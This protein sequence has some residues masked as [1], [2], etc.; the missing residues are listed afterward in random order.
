MMASSVQS[1]AYR[2]GSFTLDLGRGALLADDG[3]E[4]ALRPKSFALLRLLVE[5][6]GQLLSREAIMEALWPNVFVTEDNV[7]QCIHDIR[8]ILGAD[9]LQ[10]LRTVPRRGYLFATEVVTVTPADPWQQH[11]GMDNEAQSV[12]P[13]RLQP[14]RLPVAAQHT[15]GERSKLPRA[16]VRV[17]SLRIL[18]IPD[19]QR[20]L[21]DGVIEDICGHL[22]LWKVPVVGFS[23]ASPYIDDLIGRQN[24]ARD[25]G[26]GYLLQGSARSADD[27][28]EVN[29]Q[30]VDTEIG[31]YVWSERLSI[32]PGETTDA[33]I[34]ASLRVAR[35][36]WKA[37]GREVNR[38]LKTISP[39]QWTSDDLIHHGFSLLFRPIATGQYRDAIRL[40]EQAL[41]G[42]PDALDAKL[43]IAGA[44]ILDIADRVD[45]ADARDEAQA[46]ALILEVLRVDTN[47]MHAHMLMGVLRR[48]Q[49]RLNDARTEQE[50]AVELK[51]E[52]FRSDRSAWC[53][54]DLPWRSGGRN[55]ADREEPSVVAA[56]IQC[57]DVSCVSWSVPS[58]AGQY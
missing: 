15:V 55:S 56:G 39:Q 32:D 14:G 34:E 52:L 48:A 19:E 46:E 27:R 36:L 51:S 22:T 20:H 10:M 3:A 44:L 23:Q 26:V 21:V 53:D 1:A 9:S 30:L 37:L 58:A 50:I 54:V 16:S 47:N 57:P 35:N 24:I 33:R 13:N 41:D 42:N 45:A 11:G 7:T 6:A 49:G 2:F 29:L 18:G 28:I 17:G 8:G 12:E 43:G 40:F 31:V 25:L 4:L 5:N 38:H